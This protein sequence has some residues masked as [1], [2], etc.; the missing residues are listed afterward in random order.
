MT[1]TPSRVLSRELL[2]ASIAVF[3]TAALASFQALGLSAALPEIAGDLG[4]IELLPWVITAYLLTSSLA[5]VVAGPF[6]DS[7]GVSRMFRIAVIVFAASG[8]AAGFS[9]SM[10]MLVGLRA[11]Q[12]IGGG[13]VISTGTAA[14]SLVYPSHLVSR[15]FAANATVWGVMGVAGPAVAAAMLTFLSWHWVLFINL[16]LGVIAL[17]AGWRIF[18]GPYGVREGRIDVI[19]VVLVAALTI[20]TLFAVDSLSLQSLFW[21]GGAALATVLYVIHARRTRHPLVRLEHIVPQ[22]YRGLAMSTAFMLM[23]TMAMSDYIPLF[24]R[25]GRGASSAVTAWSVLPLTVGWTTGATLSSRLGD[26]HSE[27]WVMLLGFMINIPALALG[28]VAVTLDAAIPLTFL[29]F[30][31]AG[32]G[33]GMSTNAALTLLRALTDPSKMGRVGAAHLFARN[34]GFTF[35]AAVGGAVLLL[36]ISNTLGD[37]SLVRDLL[38]GSVAP[39]DSSEAATAVESAYATTIAVGLVL[40]SLGWLSAARLRKHLTEARLAKRGPDA[41]A[42]PG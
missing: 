5:T 39:G 8:F 34:Q 36:L 20:A 27:S 22:P 2:P 21:L 37:L 35:G 4:D 33:V 41:A 32:V 28:W 38:A 15:A 23:G 12:G 40:S 1:P 10:P 31:A 14:I 18:P 24:V 16:P 25:A 42:A 6:I 19:G 13:L 29:V 26:R 7:V 17:F 9:T 30:F 11:L 3:A